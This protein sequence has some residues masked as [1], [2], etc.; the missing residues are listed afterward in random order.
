MIGVNDVF[1]EDASKAIVEVYA[2]LAAV[3]CSINLL[4]SLIFSYFLV[5]LAKDSTIYSKKKEEIERKKKG[6]NLQ[7]GW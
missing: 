5:L 1:V 2:F 6:I 4:F 7:Q 3:P